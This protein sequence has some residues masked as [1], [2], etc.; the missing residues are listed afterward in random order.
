MGYKVRITECLD[1]ELETEMWCCNRCGTQ[2]IG[3]RENY[4]EGC[5]IYDRDP[6]EIYRPVTKEEYDFTPDPSWCRLVEFYCPG[7]GAMI[8]VEAL[9]PSH[10]LTHDIELDID[11]LKE[12]MKMAEGGGQK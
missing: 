8:E 2:I 9:P 7:C 11:S 4:K 1:I 3:A 6:S 12:R 10:P 5:L